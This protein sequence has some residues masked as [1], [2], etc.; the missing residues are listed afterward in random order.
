[1]S[2]DPQGAPAHFMPVDH[3]TPSSRMALARSRTDDSV[4]SGRSS[5]NGAS[6]EATQGSRP[7][8][9]HTSSGSRPDPSHVRFGGLF[10]GLSNPRGGTSISSSLL[11]IRPDSEDED[12]YGHT[13]ED[14]RSQR[15]ASSLYHHL[16]L[17]STATETDQQQHHHQQGAGPRASTGDSRRPR[18]PRP[19]RYPPP[20]IVAD[21][22]Q[23]QI[24]QALAESAAATTTSA[25]STITPTIPSRSTSALPS[26]SVEAA[27]SWTQ[28]IQQHQQHQQR[29]TIPSEHMTTLPRPNSSN[30]SLETVN[31]STAAGESHRDGGSTSAGSSTSETPSDSALGEDLFGRRSTRVHRRRL[32]SSSLRGLLGFQPMSNVMTEERLTGISNAEG[33]SMPEQQQESRSRQGS[34]G[35]NMER[36]RLAEM[37]FFARLISEIGRGLRGHGGQNSEGASDQVPTGSTTALS[38]PSTEFAT[39]PSLS[40][41]GPVNAGMEGLSRSGSDITVTATAPLATAMEAAPMPDVTSLPMDESTPEPSPPPVRPRRHTTIRFIQIGENG[42]FDLGGARRS[43]SRSTGTGQGSLRSDSPEG[44]TTGLAREDLADAIIMLLS[45]ASTA[46]ASLEGESSDNAPDDL[47]GS[48]PGRPSQRSPWLVLTLSGAFL[49]SLLA[50]TGGGGEGEEGG[51]MSYDDLWALSNLIGPAR[52]TTTTQEAIDNAGFHVGQ[53]DDTTKG[54]R[55]FHTLGDGSKCLVC[56][57]DYEE[58]E[59][60]R[61]LTCKHGFH[62]E[63]IDKWLTTGANK[64]PVCRAAAVVPSEGVAGG[65]LASEE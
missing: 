44:G 5:A 52:P 1:M 38:T 63:C 20:D 11:P 35:S 9:S 54:M 50:G 4:F 36:P 27:P 19:S 59:D 14:D 37:R 29:Q 13:A 30:T 8:V 64:C 16:D 34:G 46:A 57:S 47:E 2:L 24:E 61:A 26:T 31:N 65:P 43:H 17:A 42:R 49:G 62:Q 18:P 28:S 23:G 53:F 48:R 10:V 22:I 21:L 15:R 3:A 51:G 7:E 58:G 32:R 12:D 55:G 56:M 6:A 33:E 60:M 39:G 25:T 45:N 41:S 40:P